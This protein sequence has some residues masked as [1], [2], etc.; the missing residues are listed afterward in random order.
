MDNTI[1]KID[2]SFIFFEILISIV[3]YYFVIEILTL[4]DILNLSLKKS[5]VNSD[6]QAFKDFVSTRL[7]TEAF[8]IAK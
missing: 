2:I 1:A 6:Y 8:T 4:V 5:C 7:V 3:V